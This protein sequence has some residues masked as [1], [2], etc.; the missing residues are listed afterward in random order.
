MGD[1]AV[2]VMFGN[3]IAMLELGAT[4]GGDRDD[5]SIAGSTVTVVTTIGRLVANP[6]NVLQFG[7]CNTTFNANP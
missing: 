5:M 3:D 1:R 6:D 7:G 2:V 4:L